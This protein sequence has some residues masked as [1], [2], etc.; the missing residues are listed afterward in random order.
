[1]GPQAIEGVLKNLVPKDADELSLLRLVLHCAQ[2]VQK[3]SSLEPARPS[4]PCEAH[5]VFDAAELRSFVA[6][7][8]EGGRRYFHGLVEALD[9]YQSIHG[10]TLKLQNVS[11]SDQ[12]VHELKQIRDLCLQDG[13]HSIY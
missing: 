5:Q 2:Q 13:L 3:G 9:I 6:S 4:S 7:I 12:S 8:P 10:H 1:M 11:L